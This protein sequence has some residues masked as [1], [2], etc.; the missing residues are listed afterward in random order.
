MPSF[1][2]ARA[3]TWTGMLSLHLGGMVIQSLIP[4]KFTPA[5][6]ESNMKSVYIKK[7]FHVYHAVFRQVPCLV[8]KNSFTKSNNF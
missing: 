4:T 2:Y 8:S 5:Q 6:P 3:Q 1:S 7:E